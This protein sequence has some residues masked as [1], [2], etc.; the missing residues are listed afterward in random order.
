[1]VSAVLL[2]PFQVNFNI[3]YV[4]LGLLV[5]LDLPLYRQL[6]SI[7]EP[8]FRNCL[9]SIHSSYSKS[10]K[11]INL[12]E[13]KYLQVVSTNLEHASRSPLALGP[14]SSYRT[15][16][17]PKMELGPVSGRRVSEYIRL[18]TRSL[19]LFFPD[20][21]KSPSLVDR[22]PSLHK[23]TFSILQSGVVDLLSKST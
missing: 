17:L 6:V 13:T 20:I 8:V 21:S 5:E 14:K 7:W 18:D 9:P 2:Q 11:N 4:I 19:S 16:D 1:M 23:P 15:R 22:S 12:G 3:G 10:Q